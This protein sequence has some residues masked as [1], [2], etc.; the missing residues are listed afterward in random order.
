MKELDLFVDRFIA[1]L[2]IEKGL[3]RNTIESYAL[4]IARF[5]DFLKRNDIHTLSGIDTPVIIK[6]IIDLRE[7]GLEPRSRARHLA[8]LR[9]F[10]RYLVKEKVISNDP[11]RIIDIPK[12]G[13][14]LPDVLTVEEITALMDAPD[15]KKHKGVRDA[16]MIEL[17]YAAGLRVSELVHLE[18]VHVHLEAGFIRV[19]GKGSKERIIP[20]GSYAKTKVET[21]INQARPLLLKNGVSPYLFFAREG[22]P[23]TRQGFWKLLN[24]YALTAKIQKHLT[25][26]TLRHSFATH[27]LEGGADLRSVQTMLGH[28]DISTT[29]IYTHVTGKQLK[30]VHEKYHPRG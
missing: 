18:M 21:Y 22:K 4:D 11:S 12:T 8:A 10:F 1:F 2:T 25:P 3:A 28:A 26:H 5:L 16:A 19:F 14:H 20:I 29:Q 17:T 7:S 6:H 23:M 24:K 9:G 30:M 27:L 13:L 15:T